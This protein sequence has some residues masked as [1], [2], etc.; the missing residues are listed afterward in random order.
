MEKLIF[1]CLGNICRSPAAEALFNHMC[2]KRG[3]KPT[4]EVCSRAITSWNLGDPANYQM[5]IEA[6]KRGFEIP[7]KSELITSDDLESALYTLGATEEI[8]EHLRAYAPS[9]ASK[10]RI[11]LICA[12]SKSDPKADIPDPY[13]LD[14]GAFEHV[15]DMLEEAL[16]GLVE[17]LIEQ[18][19]LVP[20]QEEQ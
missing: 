4:F 17:E 16:E 7:G 20:I 15:L 6:E 5:R 8:C 3:L 19:R 13:R 12:W 14:Q 10:K 1:V 11:K 2:S 9:T 18:K